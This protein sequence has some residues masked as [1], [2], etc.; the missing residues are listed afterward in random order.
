MK[1][2]KAYKR[3]RQRESILGVLKNTSTHPTASWI[4]DQLKDDYPGLSLGTVYRNLN[5]LLEMGK[6]QK[7][8][9]GSTFDRFDGNIHPHYHFICEECGSIYDMDM[10]MDAQII[11]SVETM[12]GHSVRNYRF[13]FYGICSRC[14]NKAEN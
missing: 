7:L 8:Q 6:I 4:Y 14:K 13:E 12:S 3:S 11:H 2:E 5:I 9:F 10:D 1:S